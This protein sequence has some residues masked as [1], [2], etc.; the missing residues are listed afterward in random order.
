MEFVMERIERLLSDLQK[1][2][3]P[4]SLPI[5]QYYFRKC[6][7]R[8]LQTADFTNWEPF[9]PKKKPWDGFREKYWF[10]T[11]I[12]F[13]ES[14]LGFP[15][16]FHITTGVEGQQDLIK[17]QIYF[18]LDGKLKQGLDINH[19]TVLITEKA[20]SKEKHKIMLYA[21]TAD[22]T[23]FLELNT[24]LAIV[25][26][27]VKALYY[28]LWV[29]FQVAKLLESENE[30]R[31]DILNQLNHTVN[32]LDFSVWNS[33]KFHASV[34]EARNYLEEEFYQRMCDSQK[35]I[36]VKWV[37]HS[38]IDV[39]WLWTLDITR[40]KA[41]RTFSGMLELMKQYPEFIFTASQ[42]QLYR[43]IQ[44]DEPELYQE[45]KKK[46]QE[47][48]W[49]P[50]GAM[51]LE[52]DCNLTSGE[53]LVRQL[54]YGKQFFR[55]EFQKE[56]R[57]LW[58]PDVFG[59]SAAL[60]QILK[61]SGVD[62]FM[63]TKI[64]WNEYNKFPF[65]T[66]LWRG[67]DGSE[68]LSHF[69]PA[70]EYQD[71]ENSFTTTYNGIL[72][73]SQVKGAW[74]R[75]QQK[76]LNHEV[77][78]AAGYGDG[79]GGPTEEML[80]TAKRLSRGIPGCPRTQV[81]TVEKFFEELERQVR[82]SPRLHR[83]VGELYFEYHRGTLTSM[84]RN[85][86]YNR[87]AEFLIGSL[88]KMLC[89]ESLAQRKIEKPSSLREAWDVIMINQFHD[90]IPG[91][92]IKEVY[93]DS[94]KQYQAF[95][96]KYEPELT[97]SMERIL[98][99]I[100]LKSSSVVVFNGSGVDIDVPVEFASQNNLLHEGL[101]IS[102]ETGC[103]PLQKTWDGS[104]LFWGKEIP[105]NGYKAYQLT[106]APY[107]CQKIFVTEQQVSTPFFDVRFNQKGNII[108]I[109]DQRNGRELLTGPGNVLEVYEDRPHNWEAWDINV[110]YKEKKWLVDELQSVQ[111]LE[112]GPVRCCL[113]MTWRFLESVIEQY[114]YFYADTPRIDFKTIVDWKQQN[115]L[116]KTAFPV[117][118]HSE[119]ATY[120]IQF[121]NIRRPTHFN[122]SWDQ[123]RFE[124]CGHKWADL[125]QEDC[126]VSLLNDC[127][128]GYDIHEGVMRLT[129]IKCATYPN[130]EADQ[131]LHEF[132]YSLYPHQKGWREA[133]T[134][135][136]AYGLNN[137]PLA[138]VRPSQEGFLPDKA[139]IISCDAPNV[140][141]ET[142]KAAE[143][144]EGIICRIYECFQR[145]SVVELNV[146]RELDSLWECDL[147]ENP[148][149][150]QEFCENRF[151]FQLAPYEIKTFLLR[152][153]RS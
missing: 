139:S 35:E 65:D 25:D 83:W 34:C 140:V 138:F 49:D 123:A 28:D 133:K 88:E 84:A 33:P 126:G 40:E 13:P 90:I 107:T 89:L 54:L 14:F 52:A 45:I 104:W 145:K 87:K 134:V 71:T 10:A 1:A 12:E 99:K 47:G 128:Y 101:F 58:L 6:N 122:T 111:V 48:S 18:Y 56:S 113:K 3:Y 61:K 114:L 39:A 91:S 143:N 117:D 22:N 125:S 4:I 110:Y 109:I 29:P 2:I 20:K 105:A 17:P 106:S 24:E 85:K 32:L 41:A 77:L 68:V 79:G 124:V 137:P 53:S 146:C 142:M 86:K 70:M 57:T 95:F 127:K 102:D 31:I 46:V 72:S 150:K 26:R 97:S 66:F 80:E 148:L 62:Y 118:V 21:Y 51:Y 116:L 44:E 11:E 36:L 144:G 78:F 75:Y 141:V 81:T 7:Q 96:E 93:D 136:Q 98:E 151:Q 19:R 38:H 130:P 73:P 147:M 27:E 64:S 100:S 82:H 55:E 94:Q 5:T 121:G 43:F 152:F 16:E 76:D 115:L 67:I 132:T 149:K 74:K 9:D 37:G 59:Y 8:D 23:K 103:F 108:S 92:S 112:T 153:T 120:E 63:T 135:N 131:E 50:D 42:P 60:P 30:H 69:I 129:L 119:E 15:V